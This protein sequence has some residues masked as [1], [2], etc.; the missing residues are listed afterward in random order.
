MDF[1]KIYNNA[2]L[3]E[4]LEVE[5]SIKSFLSTEDNLNGYFNDHY[6]EIS[7]NYSSLY[8]EDKFNKT[9]PFV[10][11]YVAFVRE[12]NRRINNK[13]NIA[14]TSKVL[15]LF[16]E[17]REFID[18]TFEDLI[19]DIA[20][21]EAKIEVQRLFSNNR[22]LFDLIH[23]STDYS[24]FE[25]KEYDKILEQTD[26]YIYYDKIVYPY[27]Y[28]SKKE[29]INMKDLNLTQLNARNNNFMKSDYNN[30]FGY[31]IS[32][33][34]EDE[35]LLILHSL[36]NVIDKYRYENKTINLAEFLRVILICQGLTDSNIFQEKYTTKF[37]S[38]IIKGLDY[39]TN[40]KYKRELID[41]TLKKI[42]DFKIPEVE[43]YIK[44]L[45]K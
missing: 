11:L 45:R 12:K 16:N 43:K 41:S 44:D 6:N 9:E 3:K 22:K 25:I 24:K 2:Y 34:E 38:N 36:Y 33:L 8:K 17:K 19:K 23:Q 18:I 4:Y 42:K 10:D 40:S 32:I 31:K 27:K 29:E 30:E 5:N 37:Y 13:I 26:I 15:P 21:F 7:K 39:F 20:K 1:E 14:F 35:K 28:E